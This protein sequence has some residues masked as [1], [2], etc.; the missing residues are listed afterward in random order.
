VLFAVS[1][2]VAQAVAW[3]GVIGGGEASASEVGCNAETTKALVGKFVGDY[4]AGR[5]AAAERARGRRSLSRG[6]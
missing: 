5:V 4:N 2:N 1:A 6:F 3:K